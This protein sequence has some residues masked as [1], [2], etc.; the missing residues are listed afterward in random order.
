MKDYIELNHKHRCEST[1]DKNNQ[2]MFKL[3]NN[4]LCGR[5]LLNKMKYSRIISDINK[6]K[7]Q[8]Q[9]THSKVMILLGTQKALLDTLF[10]Q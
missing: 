8:Y 5:T 3:L 7:K 10:I 2:S 9:K 6:A 4:S 1:M